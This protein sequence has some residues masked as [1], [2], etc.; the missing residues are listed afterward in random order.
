MYQV[1]VK[2]DESGPIE[3][4]KMSKHPFTHMPDSWIIVGEDLTHAAATNLYNEYRIEAAINTAQNL[5]DIFNALDT[6][7][8][9]HK[10]GTIEE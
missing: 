7:M 5:N 9:G 1:L 10:K 3:A 2:Y 6:Y 4:R 8:A